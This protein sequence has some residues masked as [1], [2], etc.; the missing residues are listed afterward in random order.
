[1]RGS[2]L[3]F[4]LSLGLVPLSLAC[5]KGD[6][7]PPERA[8]RAA[9]NGWDMWDTDAV[10]PYKAPMPAKPEGVVPVDYDKDPFATARSKVD[11]MTPEARK[12]ARTLAYTRYCSH[13]HGANG[14]NRTIVGESFTPRLPDLRLP[15]TQGKDDRVFFHQIMH[16]SENMVPLDDTVTPVEAVLAIDHVRTLAGSPSHPLFSRKSTKPIR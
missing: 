4:L 15:E 14:D 5:D 1:M 9:F 2:R 12:A 7:F 13:C 10:S 11:A 3:V 8:L 16:G 6:Y